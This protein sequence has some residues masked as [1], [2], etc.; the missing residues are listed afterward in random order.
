MRAA[1]GAEPCKATGADLPKA[2]GA[3]PSQPCAMDVGR[4]F[5][6]DDF[7]AV[8]LSDWPAGFRTF[9]YPMSPVSVLYFFLAFFLLLLAGNVY[10]LPVESLYLGIIKLTCFLIQW[11][12]GRR[13]C[14]F[15][16]DKTL[17][18]GHWSK[19]WNELRSGRL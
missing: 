18:F 2:L 3:Q 15:V 1:T 11:L 19:C 12:M 6:K 13:G 14:R 10:P 9:M 8:G 16:S 7:G 4:G 5:K 17:G